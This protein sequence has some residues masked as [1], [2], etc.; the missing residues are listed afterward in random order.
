YCIDDEA[1]GSSETKKSEKLLIKS[2][3]DKDKPPV[4]VKSL[5]DS[6]EVERS[7]PP[8][9]SEENT[10]E[11]SEKPSSQNSVDTK[12]V[13]EQSNDVHN[14]EQSTPPG[15]PDAP[16]KT[17]PPGKSKSK[18]SDPLQTGA[19]NDE[20][21]KLPAENKL[22]GEER[23]RNRSS[24]QN[25]TTDAKSADET[26]L[27]EIK[28][29]EKGEPPGT[30]AGIN[31]SESS[32]G[33]NS[34]KSID[35]SSDRD[36]GKIKKPS[37]KAEISDELVPPEKNVHDKN[38]EKSTFE[39]AK[40]TSASKKP[41]KQ[42]NEKLNETSSEEMQ[43]ESNH[44]QDPEPTT[45]ETKTEK[46]E[47]EAIAAVR[48]FLQDTKTTPIRFMALISLQ[49]FNTKMYKYTL[50]SI[51]AEPKD[52]GMDSPNSD[53]NIDEQ[54]L[55]WCRKIAVLHFAAFC[56]QLSF[57]TSN[58]ARVS[59]EKTADLMAMMRPPM[60]PPNVKLSTHFSA[61]SKGFE[62]SILE[63]ISRCLRCVFAAS[64]T[65]FKVNYAMII[66]IFHLLTMEP[67]PCSETVLFEKYQ[68]NHDALSPDWW[69]FEG[70]P[71]REKETF[72]RAISSED[73]WQLL[74]NVGKLFAEL[75][76]I[77]RLLPRF[78]VALVGRTT[79]LNVLP[80]NWI[81]LEVKLA[82]MF[83]VFCTGNV[84][85]S[86]L[87]TL[88]AFLSS[89]DTLEQLGGLESTSLE[90]CLCISIQLTRTLALRQ[91]LPHV[92]SRSNEFFAACVAGT[93][94]FL[95]STSV[96]KQRGFETMSAMLRGEEKQFRAACLDNDS[97]ATGSKPAAR[98]ATRLLNQV[99]QLALPA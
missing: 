48:Q 59:A 49:S 56:N 53:T 5:E 36:D 69:G 6:S 44:E 33:D 45:S 70:M 92:L 41:K 42:G 12:V 26:Q 81:P 29:S 73:K 82:K 25:P 31:V 91:D 67:L 64:L 95:R 22:E 21:D 61:V 54:W 76:P 77:D 96:V 90:Q 79:S 20:Q 94:L 74:S 78:W 52:C 89:G 85:Q 10:R 84:S 38:E 19:R 46:I 27:S 47:K 28:A 30:T 7:Q 14:I 66:P 72:T 98:Q 43:T 18:M 65:D 34:S 39:K 24:A 75:S 87:V 4:D 99:A 71:L 58:V 32:K 68:I 37:S 60:T 1:S 88:H 3:E 16:T 2:Y 63:S 86:G 17:P 57:T 97:R 23:P 55:Q 15:K 8:R 80:L 50:E 51:I 40:A 13:S 62:A 83:N 93:C 11:D 35:S 9:Q